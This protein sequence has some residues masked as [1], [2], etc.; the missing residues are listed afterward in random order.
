MEWYYADD[1][2][3]QV[4]FQEEDFRSLVEIGTIKP[5]TLV[6]NATMTD[7]KQASMTQPALFGMPAAPASVA[8]APPNYYG[9]P[10]RSTDGLALASMICGIFSILMTCAYGI[11]AFPGIAAIICGHMSRKKVANGGPADGAGMATAGLIMGYIGTI[12]GILF[13]LGMVGF[14]AFAI[15]QEG[16]FE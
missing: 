12:V 8:T 10:P 13:I 7:W 9:G 1:S 5:D 14:F 2:D 16:S 4:A 15:T 3:Q 6:W 11:G